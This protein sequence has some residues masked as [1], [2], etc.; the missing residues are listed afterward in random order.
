MG[1]WSSHLLYD[2][3][4]M[5]LSYCCFKIKDWNFFKYI[6]KVTDPGTGMDSV[7]CSRT[8]NNQTSSFTI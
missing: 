2:N 6:N 8:P 5:M 3:V 4:M 1:T 7:S